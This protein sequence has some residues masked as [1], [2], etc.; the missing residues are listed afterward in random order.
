M[1]LREGMKTPGNLAFY[2]YLWENLYKRGQPKVVL[3]KCRGK[4]IAGGILPIYKDT[5]YY[6]DRIPFAH[7]K[8][9]FG[10]REI[11]YPYFRMTRGLLGKVGYWLYQRHRHVLK[12]RGI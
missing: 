4:A 5:I 7:S 8:R 3:V 12:R 10:G 1:Y 6:L 11:E 9:G 2:Q